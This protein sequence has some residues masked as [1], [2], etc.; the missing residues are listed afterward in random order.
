MEPIINPWIFYLMDLANGLRA[1]AFG[2]MM[3]GFLIGGISLMIYGMEHDKLVPWK[4]LK[5]FI[6][7]IAAGG[8]L[9][10]FIPTQE[11]L[12]KMLVASF[13][14]P[15]NINLGIEGVQAIFDYII[16]TAAEFF[17]PAAAGG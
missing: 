16:E 17:G 14:T 7:A 12:T 4:Y 11:T 2:T 15:D 13:I 1:V 10:I 5:W 6:I 3:L 8:V 9:T